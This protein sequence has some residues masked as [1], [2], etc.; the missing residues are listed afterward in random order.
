MIYFCCDER[1]RALVR[2]SGL[3]DGEK[4]N[5]ID[6][7]EIDTEA[8]TQ[9]ERQHKLR[10][11]FL[12]PLDAGDIVEKNLLIEGGERIRGIEVKSADVDTSDHKILVVEVGN[13][14]TAAGATNAGVGDFS[15]YTLRLVKDAQQAGGTAGGGQPPK[16]FDPVL[17]A[18]R[19]SFKIECPSDFDCRPER[20]CPPESRTEPEI[21]YLAKDYNSF[22]QL[23]LDRISVLMPQWNERNAAD[24]GVALVEMLA[25]VGDHL[26]YQQD[27]V[28][29]EAYLGTARRRVSV[30]RHALLVDYFMHDGCNARAWIH[31]KVS[32]D[33][34]QLMKGARL[35]TSLPGLKPVVDLNDSEQRGLVSSAR[36]ESFETMQNATFFTAHNE[37]EFYTWAEERCCLPAGA[38]SATLKGNLP[39]LL[40]GDVLVFEEIAGPL[41]GD[42]ADADPA[43]R[44]AV[45]LTKVNREIQTEDKK[46]IPL[47]DPL[48]GQEYVEIEWHTD[49]ALPFALCIS[50]R[51]DKEYLEKISVARG[52]IVLADHGLTLE[53]SLGSPA[54]ADEALAGVSG[55]SSDCCEHPQATPALPRFRPQLKKQPLTQ[56]A[57]NLRKE[58]QT[59]LTLYRDPNASAAAVFRWEMRSVLPEISLE[60]GDG[61]PWS[62]KRDLLSSDAFKKEFVAEVDEDGRATLRFG[63]DQYGLRPMP[64]V[65]ILARY[66]VG[67]GL[68]GNVGAETLVHIVTTDPDIV[69]VSNPMA[70]R[71]GA[72]PES[73]EHVRRVAPD[74]FRIQERAV[75]PEDYAAVAMRHREVQ[76]AAATVRWTGSWRTIFLTID[77]L[78]G[79]PVDAE[80]EQD[81]RLHLERYRMAGHD[82]EIA[83]PQFV[84]LEIAVTVCVQPSY[85]RSDVKAALLRVF[86][87]TTLP[88]GSR[89]LFHPDNF[90]FGQPVYLSRIYAAAQA[91]EGVRFVT[92]ETFQRLGSN[93]SN[94]RQ[95]L[96]DGV[97][98]LERLEVARLDN[99]PNFAESGVFRL[100]MEGGK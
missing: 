44:H 95:A 76:D 47:K 36:T 24:L 71:G 39:N 56:A 34:V 88:D 48:N 8:P 17:S 74:A 51:P 28:A 33:N 54:P 81:L 86:S 43:H 96:D 70:A 80:F 13:S 41:T 3:V 6:F 20:I 60:D 7:L 72:D 16:G 84:P 68:S 22:R 12:K 73:I 23:M 18:V 66:R 69:S 14:P 98:R 79:R 29:T 2:D 92:I 67:N 46:T 65:E 61:R 52:N 53:E 50:A 19:F 97:L 45:R 91:V 55:V 90:S 94:S 99:N 11:H 58:S 25:Y 64:D 35:I 38:T 32:A 31:F 93:S 83:G 85:F 1:R 100:N 62:P 59:Q 26:S 49:D 10:V 77:R 40:P 15:I 42:P 4:Y 63:D 78:G 21:D 37:I 9:S 57:R 75:T 30:R 82:V 27:A 87:N 5:G 89:G